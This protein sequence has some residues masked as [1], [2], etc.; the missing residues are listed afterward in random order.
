M[1]CICNFPFVY[2]LL[3]FFPLPIF[4]PIR[5][6]AVLFLS[7]INRFQCVQLFP[8]SE[9]ESASLIKKGFCSTFW[10]G[11]LDLSKAPKLIKQLLKIHYQM[12]FGGMSSRSS[13]LLLLNAGGCGGDALNRQPILDC[14][15]VSISSHP[16]SWQ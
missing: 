6:I 5:V 1:P 14:L 15:L 7:G 11:I 9:L 4:E 8:D 12:C 16:R 2:C 13:R 3:L 10:R